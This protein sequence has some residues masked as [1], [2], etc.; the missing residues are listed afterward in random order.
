MI[1]LSRLNTPKDTAAAQALAKEYLGRFPVG[2][3][4]HPA[5]KLL[6][7]R[8]PPRLNRSPNKRPEQENGRLV[9]LL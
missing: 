1:V 9:C 8:A 7:L 3:Y 5:R 4:A 6:D 2:P